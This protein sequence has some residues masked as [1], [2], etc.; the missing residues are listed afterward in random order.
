MEVSPKEGMAAHDGGTRFEALWS[1]VRPTVFA[2]CLRSLRDP[3]RAE[4]VVQIVAI[5]AWRGYAGFRGTSPFL[6]WVMAIARREVAREA[7]RSMERAFRE[8]ADPLVL[9]TIPVSPTS[10]P[11]GGLELPWTELI[12][13][14]EGAGELSPLEA[15]VLRARLQADP[16]SWQ[17]LGQRV[18][19]SATAC[20]AA[21]CRAIPKLRV[22]LFIYRPA[23]A[24]TGA[25][26][27]RAF[28]SALTASSDPLR[29]R[30]AEAFRMLVLERRPY[31]RA[32]WRTALRSACSKVMVCVSQAHAGVSG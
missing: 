21:H 28:A 17:E 13:A 8:T 26:L 10:G 3:H 9:E 6:A 16:P 22:F 32:G 15:E 19:Q 18:H 5:R 11:E 7:A 2:Y 30:E 12:E 20:A 14:A 27:Q 31:R 29:P 25:L 23:W 24:G 4:D 1:G